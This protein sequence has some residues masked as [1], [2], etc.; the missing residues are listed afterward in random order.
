MPTIFT[1]SFTGV[2]AG[3]AVYDK[4]LPKRFWI[5]SVIC[6]IIP[7][8]DVICFKIGIPYSHFFGHRGFFHSLFFAC[9]LGS[10]IGVLFMKVREKGWKQK[11]F[12]AVYFSFL[13]VVHDILD[14]FTN[15][16]LGIALLSPFTPKRYF[17]W[18][19]PI[20]VSPI[21][22]EVFFSGKALFILK[23]EFFWVWIPCICIAIL[24]RIIITKRKFING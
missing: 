18:V 19:T 14:A 20:E 16:G 9:I 2:A 15:G 5:F 23:N 10:L 21:N 7:D 22:P 11:L 12:F 1:H 8:A 13:I 6:S 24:Y 3:I 4:T 17:F